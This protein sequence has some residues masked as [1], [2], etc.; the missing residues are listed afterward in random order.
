MSVFFTS[1][2]VLPQK[3]FSTPSEFN[4]FFSITNAYQTYCFDKNVFLRCSVGIVGKE[5]MLIHD[6]AF[7]LL[8]GL[9][10]LS[11]GGIKG[12]C[13][14]PIGAFGLETDHQRC[15]KEGIVHLG[16]SLFYVVDVFLSLSNINNTYPQGLLRKIENV[17]TT[18]LETTNKKVIIIDNPET[19]KA[20]RET[21]AEAEAKAFALKLEQKKAQ[22]QE[23]ALSKMQEELEKERNSGIL[24]VEDIE[25]IQEEYKELEKQERLVDTHKQSFTLGEEPDSMRQKEPKCF[26]IEKPTFTNYYTLHSWSVDSG[27]SEDEEETP[28]F[29]DKAALLEKIKHIQQGQENL[30]SD[31]TNPTIVK[32]PETIAANPCLTTVE[33]IKPIKNKKKNYSPQSTLS[34]QEKLTRRLN[35]GKSITSKLRDQ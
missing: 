7:H 4:T 21:Q 27:E 9:V 31:K 16:F 1:M 30:L 17:F 19:E 14:I 28:W 22:E 8:G 29:A 13:A 3:F 11:L 23:E 35:Y 24:T 20:L 26:Q 2:A 15:I 12:L 32:E 10:K 6:I 25:A 34:A 18:F 5:A 33:Q